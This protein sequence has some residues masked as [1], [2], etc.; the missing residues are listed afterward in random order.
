MS[1]S[2]LIKNSDINIQTGI[3]TFWRS[4]IILSLALSFKTSILQLWLWYSPNQNL[5]LNYNF[6]RNPCDRDSNK[7]SW[8]YILFQILK[9]LGRNNLW[10]L[11]NVTQLPPSQP[12]P[13]APPVSHSYQ[14]L[15][16]PTNPCRGGRVL[17]LYW[18]S[19]LVH[20]TEESQYV[21]YPYA[22][23]WEICS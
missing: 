12:Q 17:F 11:T 1:K 20:P 10:F 9:Q 22:F 21:L 8:I 23:S 14:N 6:K 16:L 13:C 7:I 2:L 15:V 4:V 19:L 18:T 3:T 5:Y